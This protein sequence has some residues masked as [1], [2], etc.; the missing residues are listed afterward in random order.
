MYCSG[1]ILKVFSLLPQGNTFTGRV[2]SK[3]ILVSCY[4]VQAEIRK[5]S[6]PEA[7][8]C[9]VEHMQ[10]THCDCLEILGGVR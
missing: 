7:S 9:V 1:K 2:Q 5:C 4:T 6:K 8:Q 3:A 10:M